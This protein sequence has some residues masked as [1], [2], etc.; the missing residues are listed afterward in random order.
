MIIIAWLIFGVVCAWIAN[1]R[2]RS[3]FGWFVLGCL[4]GPLALII[5]L[6][7]GQGGTGWMCPYC[8]EDVQ[9]EAR[10]CPHCQKGIEF[11]PTT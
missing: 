2:D 4:F 1:G 7:I 11:P 3:G 5:L 8:R 6:C 9:K 10:V